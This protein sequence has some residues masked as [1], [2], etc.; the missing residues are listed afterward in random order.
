MNN[1]VEFI[2]IVDEEIAKYLILSGFSYMLEQQNKQ[3]VYVFVANQDLLHALNDKFS[4]REFVC[5]NKL[6]F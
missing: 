3:A 2:K 4:K 6:R 1:K 5:D